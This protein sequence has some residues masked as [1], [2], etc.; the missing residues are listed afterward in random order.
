MY[1]NATMHDCYAYCQ[2]HFLLMSH[3]LSVRI[4]L[5]HSCLV[6]VFVH[7]SN[8]YIFRWFVLYRKYGCGSFVCL[9]TIRNIIGECKGWPCFVSSHCTAV[10]L[11][12]CT[13]VWVSLFFCSV[14]LFVRHLL[15]IKWIHTFADAISIQR[16]I[17]QFCCGLLLGFWPLLFVNSLFLSLSLS[18]SVCLWH[19][20]T[21]RIRW[22]LCA[23]F[24][25]SSYYYRLVCNL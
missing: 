14:P 11:S 25:P 12:Q 1:I 18:F 2:L 23:Y 13:C 20:H 10:F 19:Q 5:V 9:L 15:D 3:W 24:L 21:P 6:S 22:L 7:V 16:L 4:F 17:I 8:Y